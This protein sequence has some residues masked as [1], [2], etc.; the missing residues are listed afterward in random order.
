MS[1]ENNKEISKNN[2]D[3][4]E[5]QNEINTENEPAE[6]IKNSEGKKSSVLKFIL[7][8]AAVFLGVFTATYAV[9]DRCMYKMGIMPFVVSLEKA[10]KM[11]DREFGYAEKN[12]P[13][14]VKI[15][16]K[17]NEA[18]VTVDLKKFDNNEDNVNIEFID[19]GIK[20]SGKV[21]KE[22][23]NGV[24]ESSFVQNVIFPDEFEKENIQKTKKRNKIVIVLPF[25]NR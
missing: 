6:E 25:K 20:I 12:S 1:E 3:N 16:Q 21:K 19:N 8:V 23:K 18:V 13:A 10:Q 14:P 22:N 15:E 7:I 9:V 4:N 2:D 17:D 24:S 11:F 5:L